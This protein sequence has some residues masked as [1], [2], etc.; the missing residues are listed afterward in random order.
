MTATGGIFLTIVG[1]NTGNENH[2][3]PDA[4]PVGDRGRDDRSDGWPR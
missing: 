3:V 2:P 1:L 4:G